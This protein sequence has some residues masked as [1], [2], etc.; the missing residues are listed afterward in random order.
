[1]SKFF[2]L[3]FVAIVASVV[4]G[5]I[6]HFETRNEVNLSKEKCIHQIKQTYEH[7][8]K[9]LKEDA[10]KGD[11]LSRLQHEGLQAFHKLLEQVENGVMEPNRSPGEHSSCSEAIL[12]ELYHLVHL[13][14]R[15]F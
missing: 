12:T 8:E 14:I 11:E 7:A 6:L 15:G 3:I 1:M 9:H 13:Y 2:I 10:T 5:N 4:S